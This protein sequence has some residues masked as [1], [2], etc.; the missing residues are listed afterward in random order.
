MSINIPSDGL[1]HD[2]VGG[3][4]APR[5]WNVFTLWPHM[6]QFA[7]HQK[8]VITPPGGS[9]RTLLDDAYASTEQRNYPIPTLTIAK[10]TRIDVTCTYVNTSGVP[11]RFGDSSN[12]EMCF[13]GMYKYPAGGFLFECL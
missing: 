13:T 1:P 12:E 10:G 5:D 6:H 4:T 8:V 9:P 3:C 11:L 7:T 2:V